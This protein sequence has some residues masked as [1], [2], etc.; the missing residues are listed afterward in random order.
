[1][2]T[3]PLFEFLKNLYANQNC[4]V[5]NIANS[6]LLQQQLQLN[7]VKQNNEA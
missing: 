7:D 6:L 5:A 2:L 3:G 4:N 1:M